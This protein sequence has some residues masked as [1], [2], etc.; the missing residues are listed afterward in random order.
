MHYFSKLLTF[1]ANAMILFLLDA[2]GRWRGPR[3]EICGIEK[4]KACL[5][6]F[7]AS[8]IDRLLMLDDFLPLAFFSLSLPRFVGRAQALFFLYLSI[9][10]LG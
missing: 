2:G 6:P 1:L 7:E 9:V 4:K 8:V 3:D 5:S 10:S